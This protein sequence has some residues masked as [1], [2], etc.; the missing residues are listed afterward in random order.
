MFQ[1]HFARAVTFISQAATLEGLKLT[2]GHIILLV[3]RTLGGIVESAMTFESIATL[4]L[5]KSCYFVDL[6]VKNLKLVTLT[7][8]SLDPLT[9][10]T[11]MVRP[12]LLIIASSE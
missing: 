7:V 12:E 10:L 2:V 1:C 3:S 4:P 11:L 5:P 6:F 8:C 9:G